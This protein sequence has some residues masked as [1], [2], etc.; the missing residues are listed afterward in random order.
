MSLVLCLE[1]EFVS[2]DPNWGRGGQWAH[3]HH[4]VYI[5]IISGSWNSWLGFLP[6]CFPDTCKD[7]FL[8]LIC[9]SLRMMW[10]WKRSWPDSVNN[11]CIYSALPTYCEGY[12]V[13]T[14]PRHDIPFSGLTAWY[15][16]AGEYTQLAS[17]RAWPLFRSRLFSSLLASPPSS[18]R[19][20]DLDLALRQFFPYVHQVSPKSE[21]V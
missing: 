10:P 8:E 20:S 17:C 12:C 3:F 18:V 4:H 19:T 2:W 16:K 7:V 1:K 14:I 6:S 5:W 13:A 11:W 9:V 21:L 15:R